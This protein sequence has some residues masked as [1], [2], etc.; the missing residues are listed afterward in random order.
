MPNLDPWVNQSNDYEDMQWNEMIHST[1]RLE[2]SHI[3][4]ILF[5]DRR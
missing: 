3:G 2:Y 1:G 4:I 5:N